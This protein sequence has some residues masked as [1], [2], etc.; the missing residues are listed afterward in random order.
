MVWT[1]SDGGERN[2][3]VVFR[4]TFELKDKASTA[5]INLYADSRYALYVNEQY[6]G[7][8]PARSYHRNPVYDSYD[9][10]PYLRKGPNVIAI[11]AMSNGML[12]YQLFDYKGAFSVWGKIQDGKQNIDLDVSN[13]WLCKKLDGYDQSAPRFSFA[14]GPIENWDSRGEGDWYKYITQLK[15]WQKPVPVADQKRWGTFQIRPIPHLS[16]EEH[17]AISLRGAYHL[18][19][20]ED[21]YS[22][23][24][25]TLD[26]DLSEYNRSHSAIAYTY[27]YS[28]EDQN[29]DVGL[30]WGDY[31][32]NGER[33]EK[34]KEQSRESYRI[35]YPLALKKG[36]NEFIVRYGIIWGSWDFYIAIPKDRGIVLSATKELD[37]PELFY[38]YGPFVKEDNAEIK[39]IDISHSVEKVIS[40]T[41]KSWKQQARTKDANQPARDLAWYEPDTTRSISLKN[42]IEGFWQIPGKDVALM[43]EMGE[44]QL[45]RLF[46]EGNFPEGTCI[47]I[48]F[49][50]ELDRYG[51]PWLY[52]RYQV[53]AGIRFIADGIGTRYESFKPYGAK[54]IHLKITGHNRPFSL[55]KV[56][57]VR[58][59]YPFEKIGSFQCSDP[60]L[61]SI[62]EAGWRTLQL[63][64]ED[65]YTDTPFRERGLYAGDMLPEVAITMA[66]SGD[67]RLAKYSLALFQDMYRESMWEGKPNRHNDFPLLTLLTLDWV[68]TYAQD[69]TQMEEFYANYASLLKHHI[70]NQN[71]KGLVPANR[72]FLEWTRLNKLNAAMTAYQALLVQSMKVM[73]RWAESLGKAEDKIFFAREADS[74]SRVVNQ[75]FWNEEKSAFADGWQSDTVIQSYFLSSSIWPA[76]YELASD[77]QKSRILDRLKLE[78]QDIGDQS[79][80]RKITPYSSFYLFALLYREGRA[81]LAEYFMRKHWGPMALHSAKPTVWENFD[82]SGNQGT[83]S[84]AWSGH[85][86]FFLATETLGVNLGFNKAFDPDIIEIMPQSSSLSWAEGTVVHPKGPVHVRWEVRGKQLWVQY[87][88]PKGIRVI[89]NPKGR[90]GELELVLKTN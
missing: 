73:S 83:S 49:S 64:S 20:S 29:L 2:E 9:L 26:K 24:L 54:Y 33:L 65:S 66:V 43:F 80:K 19:D 16:Q 27:I 88:A 71:A 18:K 6:I 28:P 34:H 60:L 23:R 51:F 32:L 30:W 57:M 87:H 10:R 56:G 31:Y 25:A 8:G 58:Q 82:I 38:T 62:W 68:S 14:T 84:H 1:N 76:L 70:A 17:Q 46:V 89:V 45:G 5:E 63:C 55:K 74:L 75:I 50:E 53:G 44:T 7:F 36:W 37:S 48:G 59:V 12:T 61:N 69:W 72:V 42:G 47:D 67:L 41:T 3:Y 13:E 77:S 21:I 11:K 90:L 79:R 22:F 15:D 40:Q 78:L 81:E 52:K 39:D 85:P 86:T 35:Q 4:K